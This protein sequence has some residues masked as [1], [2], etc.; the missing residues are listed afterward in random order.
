[1]GDVA[2]MESAVTRQLQHAILQLCNEHV[3]YEHTLQVLGVICVTVDDRPRD[4]VVKLNN[5]LK[6]VDPVTPESDDRRVGIGRGSAPTMWPRVAGGGD[7]TAACSSSA[8]AGSS[9]TGYGG[10]SLLGRQGATTGTEAATDSS[11][12]S[13]R[14]CHG[15][16]QSNPMKVKTVMDDDDNDVD[17]DHEYSTSDYQAS[18][19]LMIAPAEP[20][21]AEDDPIDVTS[22]SSSPRLLLSVGGEHRDLDE[23]LSQ[24]G[25]HHTDMPSDVGGSLAVRALLT[26]TIEKNDFSQGVSSCIS[27]SALSSSLVDTLPDPTECRP[28]DSGA[29]KLRRDSASASVQESALNFSKRTSNQAADS[30]T[31]PD[32]RT[33]S[34]T[35]VKIKEEMQHP[36]L[37]LTYGLDL[38][39]GHSSTFDM[40][41][42]LTVAA[43]AAALSQY[44]DDPA[45]LQ[46]LTS[47]DQQRL[48]LYT[49][50][51]TAAA[52]S[53]VPPAGCDDEQ[54]PPMSL[55]SAA[56]RRDGGA[57]V[58]SSA[59]DR[60]LAMSSYAMAGQLGDSLTMHRGLP[61]IRRRERFARDLHHCHQ[62]PMKVRMSV[63]F[64]T[65]TDFARLAIKKVCV[66]SIQSTF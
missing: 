23:E 42:S 59:L 53:G 26:G 54:P 20:S 9:T 19:V 35:D 66:I 13:L 29:D 33:P 18:G 49:S 46:S 37:P 6:R 50:L 10:D 11:S 30:G 22:P 48:A 63:M 31:S 2:V 32:C 60:P 21:A 43:A 36:A 41:R 44:V 62:P 27:R 65:Q 14:K 28:T 16:K 24:R 12:S 5:T 38:G 45:I 52:A 1:M 57:D 17:D 55:H 3:S 56:G 15:R 7:A 40:S 64:P 8:A 58:P 51:V 34:G 39:G 47:Y 25:R 4:V 61:A